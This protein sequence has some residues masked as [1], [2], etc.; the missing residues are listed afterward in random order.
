MRDNDLV[1]GP[2]LRHVDE[3]SAT[4]WVEIAKRGTVSVHA[5]GRTWSAPSFSAHGHHYAVL[6]VEQ[7]QPGSTHAYTVDVDG[8]SV[9]PLA[10]AGAPSRIRTLDPDRPLRLA[11]GS[12]RTSVPHDAE[13]NKSHGID[14][15][16]AYALRMMAA[17]ENYDLWPDLVLFLGDQ[18]Y[19]DETSDGMQ[20][21]IASRRSLEE[22]PGEELKDFEE[23]AHL[24]SLAWSDPANR[25][26]LSTLSC[27]MIFDDHDVRDDWNTS[28]DWRQKM[29]A[30]PWWQE[31]IV[32]GLASYWIY[33]HLGNL[34]PG[35]RAQDDIWRQVLE[36]RERGVDDIT[37]LLDR[38]ATST[39]RRPPCGWR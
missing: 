15:L 12:C 1:L 22:G 38:F 3:T 39:K 17:G 24:Y 29:K 13:G 5:D 7:L 27:A 10:D 21:F 34:T 32:G 31:R 30:T 14:V 28:A 4:V 2:L 33:Q 35:E 9:W 8:T 19:A 20:E 16:R 37:E 18:V 23:Y 6:D 11:F 25:W 36:L 26:L